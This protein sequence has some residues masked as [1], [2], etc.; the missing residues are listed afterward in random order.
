MLQRY[1]IALAG[2]SIVTLV[3]MY[4]MSA[5]AEYFNRP[6]S[7]VYLRV[8]D[9]IPGSGARRLQPGPAHGLRSDHYARGQTAIT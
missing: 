6:D 3:L 5:I 1:A 4:G 8:M 7:Q 2:A 9:V